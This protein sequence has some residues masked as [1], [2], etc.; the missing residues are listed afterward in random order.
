L[1]V[2]PIPF[3]RIRETKYA[4]ASTQALCQ[5]HGI[6]YMCFYI[7]DKSTLHL[8]DIASY[9][10]PERGLGFAQKRGISWREQL[11]KEL[12]C[13]NLN[14][15]DLYPL[16]SDRMKD[17]R[18][19]NR[20]FDTNHWN[21]HGL[22]IGYEFIRDKMI[23][24]RPEDFPSSTN[25]AK[26]EFYTEQF[27]GE[28]VVHIK[29]ANSEDF[30]IINNRLSELISNYSE[31][32][33]NSWTAPA[34][35]ENPAKTKGKIFIASDSYLKNSE[36]VDRFGGGVG[37]IFPLLGDVHEYLHM[38][39]NLVTPYRTK[40]IIEKYH[41]DF[42]IEEFVEHMTQSFRTCNDPYMLT[43]ADFLLQTSSARVLAPQEMPLA[44][45]A[46]QQ[47]SWTEK[48]DSLVFHSAGSESYINTDTPPGS[49]YRITVNND[50]LAVLI[51]RIESPVDT[52]AIWEVKLANEPNAEWTK[53]VFKMKKGL[54]H[55]RIE[56][57]G[58]PGDVLE[59]KFTPGQ[60]AGDYIFHNIPEVQQLRNSPDQSPIDPIQ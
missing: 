53:K 8:K 60:V 19:Y 38:H 11:L 36:S 32:D 43:L 44:S 18:V 59:W 35:I 39:Y 52:D 28:N 50:R 54:N 1:G 22:M 40:E 42:Y 6:P 17:G 45:L 23:K 49:D 26:L 57:E 31:I 15:Y 41:P 37:R 34:Y 33:P 29:F 14:F 48:G 51:A 27:E 30:N 24:Q 25:S 20:K 7:P 16:L 55:V 56:Y 47:S 2:F 4:I 13:S 3:E 46:S 9:L 58:N 21:A 12:E 5:L 10:L